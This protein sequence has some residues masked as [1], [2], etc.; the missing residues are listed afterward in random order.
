[1]FN[2]VWAEGSLEA[3]NRSHYALATLINNMLDR[4]EGLGFVHRNGFEQLPEDAPGA[5]IVIHGEHLMGKILELSER[6]KNLRWAISIIIGD[7]PAQFR[8][9]F[10]VGDRKKVWIQ[11]PIPG[12]SDHASRRLICGYPHDAPIFLANCADLIAKK[13]LDWSFAGQVNNIN[14]RQ[15]AQI[16]RELKN[17]FLYESPRFWSGIPRD[18]Y[19][20]IMADSKVVVCPT[21]A[22]TPDTLRVAEALEAGC[23]PIVEDRWPSSTTTGYW[24]Y[25]L[26]EEP[27]FPLVTQW[28]DFTKVL[29]AT[30]A[31]WP[32]ICGNLQLWWKDYKSRMCSWL[33]EDM[34][35]VGAL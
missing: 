21:G 19:Y 20:G 4:T 14:R 31:G 6:I 13:S 26:G 28:S 10:L 11:M 25:V 33:S 3:D 9:N 35:L 15:C 8:S 23:V 12:R 1:M 22:C 7:E 18:E 2:C 17:G 24:K 16:L 29:D 30:L 27:P 5:V 34:K 32:T